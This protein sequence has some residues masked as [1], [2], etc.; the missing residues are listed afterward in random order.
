L[1]YLPNNLLAMPIAPETPSIE[2]S[3]EPPLQRKMGLNL[4]KQ[5]GRVQVLMI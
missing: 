5:M 1:A 3:S 4:S 2:S